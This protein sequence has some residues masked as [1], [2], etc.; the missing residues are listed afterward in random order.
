MTPLSECQEIGLGNTTHSPVQMI[1]RTPLS[2][3]YK[4]VMRLG[5]STDVLS[6]SMHVDFQQ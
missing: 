1:S 4:W 2:P 3:L 6:L 5:S